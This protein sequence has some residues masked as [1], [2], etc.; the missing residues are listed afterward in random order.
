MKQLFLQYYYYYFSRYASN[1]GQSCGYR[2]LSNR[3]KKSMRYY[4]QIAQNAA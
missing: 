2:A 3:V 4:S 1:V